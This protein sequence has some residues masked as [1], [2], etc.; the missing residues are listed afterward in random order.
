MVHLRKA[1]LAISAACLPLNSAVAAD[2]SFS[3]FASAAGGQTM[4]SGEE[5]RGYGHATTFQ[6]DTKLGFQAN[7]AMGDGLN[8]TMQIMGKSAD[9]FATTMEW[10]FISKNVGDNWRFDFGRQRVPFYMYSSY[11]DVGIAYHWITPP[12]GVYSISFSSFDGI[13]AQHKTDLGD[14]TSTLKLIL[15]EHQ[16]DLAVGGGTEEYPATLQDM[17]GLRWSAEYD[18]LTF[19][20]GYIHLDV[21]VDIPGVAALAGG[22]IKTGQTLSDT[23]LISAGERISLDGRTAEYISTG[24]RIDY[25]DYLLVAEYSDLQIDDGFSADQT[26]LYISAGKTIGDFFL[27]ATYTQDEDKPDYSITANLPFYPPADPDPKNYTD[28]E[29][30]VAGAK[31]LLAGSAAES[32]S[33]IFGVNYKFHTNAV[34]KVEYTQYTDDLNSGASSNDS[35]SIA[36][37]IDTAF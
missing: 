33:Y 10:A 11:L 4:E 7:F 14:W 20:L 27:H 16:S 8:A 5:Y 36:F 19:E 35:D 24:I 17:M 6:P 9:S 12:P 22:L 29:T 30:L 31:G 26:S 23:S 1:L 13:S 28:E 37:S 21:S 25:E 18:W 32:T 2:V 15:G 3:G 34:A